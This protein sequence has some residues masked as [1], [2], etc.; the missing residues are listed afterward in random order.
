MN[1]EIII[2]KNK[3]KIGGLYVGD[4]ANKVD[5]YD[6]LMNESKNFI[7]DGRTGNVHLVPK[8]KE[9]AEKYSN[10]ICEKRI[11]IKAEIKDLIKE[12]DCL[13]LAGRAGGGSKIL[14]KTDYKDSSYLFNYIRVTCENRNYDLVFN[15][16]SRTRNANDNMD[17]IS[18]ILKCLQYEVST[19][20]KSINIYPDSLEDDKAYKIDIE[21]NVNAYYNPKVKFN[22]SAKAIAE[23]FIDFIKRCENIN[24]MLR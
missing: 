19:S 9:L 12:T 22:D 7:F 15:R 16:F 3:C 4:T 14:N 20:V 1:K 6:P 24:I 11:E 17:E 21:K 10:E 18:C 23:D 8:H 5:C 2:E 13:V